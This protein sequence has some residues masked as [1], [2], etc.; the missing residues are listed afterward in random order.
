MPFSIDDLKE[1]LGDRKEVFQAEVAKVKIATQ[2]EVASY[3]PEIQL[4]DSKHIAYFPFTVCNSLPVRNKRGRCFT[5]QVLQNSFQSLTDQLVNLEHELAANG[6]YGDS[7]KIVGHIKTAKFVIPKEFA[8]SKV[9]SVN[10]LPLVPEVPFPVIGL[11]VVYLRSQKGREIVNRHMSETASWSSSMECFHDIRKAGLMYRGDYIPINEADPDMIACIERASVRPY[12]GHELSLA[13]GGRDG[14]VEFWG[15]ALTESPA[16]PGAP[17]FCFA[18]GRS[19]EL[20]STKFFFMPAI[21]EVLQNSECAS[22]FVDKQF[23]ELASIVPI[24][25]TEADSTDGHKH[26]ILSDH[27]ILPTNGHS[28]WL[29]RFSTNR[30]TKPSLTGVT[31]EQ[32]ARTPMP[33]GS[34]KEVVHLHLVSIP[35]TGKYKSG[36]ADVLSDTED[37]ASLLESGDMPK[38]IAQILGEVQALRGLI[39]G[40]KTDD[41]SKLL[42]GVLKDFSELA[43]EDNI[44]KAVEAKI[45]AKLK[46]GS[47]V[48]KEQADAAVAEALDTVKKEQEEK[49]RLEGIKAKRIEG[50][51][52]LGINPDAILDADKNLTIRAS[53][54]AIPLDEAGD[55]L[56]A[57]H[58]STLNRLKDSMQEAS[59]ATT[60]AEVA[61]KKKEEDKAK[62]PQPFLLVGAGPTGSETASTTQQTQQTSGPKIGKNIFS[63]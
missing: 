44:T 51:T 60:A 10:S 36:V 13:L 17:V 3:F 59:K 56:Y 20:A 21:A 37:L 38:T 50:V 34:T 19:K 31:S 11:G 61:S 41:A 52:A 47:I 43:S 39:V 2:E 49:A 58:L 32:Y 35:L 28:H 16:D 6:G 22:E 1:R 8:S 62:K 30:G 5:P 25:E 46:D 29:S 27:T 26:I 45:A 9:D 24:G 57:I 53:V 4:S 40:N 33:D 48:T 18:G 15:S 12:K 54:E 55:N 14:Q 42:D 63:S 7:D 23:N